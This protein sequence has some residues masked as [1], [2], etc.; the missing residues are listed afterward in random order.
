V[1]VLSRLRDPVRLAVGTL[2]IVPTGPPATVDRRVA[3][4]AMTF[5]P[6]VGFLLAVVCGLFLWLLGRGPGGAGVTRLVPEGLAGWQADPTLAAALTIGLLAVLTRAIH[7]DGLADTADGLGSGRPADAALK[8]MRRGDVGPFGVVTLVLVLLVQVLALGRLVE[9]GQGPSAL[10]LALVVSRLALPMLCWQGVPSARR[11]GLGQV[12]A[13]SVSPARLLLATTLAVAVL[14][15]PAVL[16]TGPH[17][18]AAGILVSAGVAA[19]LGLLAAGLLG[20][21][22]VRRLGGLTGDVLGASVETAFTTVLVVLT[23]VV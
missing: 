9:V 22:A 14:V 18:R 21:R 12:V 1:T 23:L 2:T 17:A 19:L 4:W 15:L 3:G 7:L 11:D 13:A 20:R 16:A 8:V 10:L 6:L 5:A